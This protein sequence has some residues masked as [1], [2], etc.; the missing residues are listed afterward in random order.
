[1]FPLTS[2]NTKY[3]Y[4]DIVFFIIYQF[5]STMLTYCLKGG[6]KQGLLKASMLTKNVIAMSKAKQYIITMTAKTICSSEIK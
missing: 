6:I 3:M 5:V 1:M 2:S 4:T